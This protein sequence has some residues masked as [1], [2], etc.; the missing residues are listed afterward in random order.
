[1]IHNIDLGYGRPTITLI[2]SQTM[3]LIHTT[4]ANYAAASRGG[5]IERIAEQ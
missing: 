4:G 3:T 2:G 1:M 5:S